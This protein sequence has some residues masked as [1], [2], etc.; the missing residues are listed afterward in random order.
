MPNSSSRPALAGTGVSG[1]D[2]VLKGGLPANRLYLLKGTPGTGKTTLA[3]QFLL[4]GARVGERTLYIALSETGDEIT[5]VAD[6]HG[7]D[8]SPLGIFELST[9]ESQIA[10]EAQNTIYHPAE[11][12]LNK[13]TE[14]I[15]KQIE[16]VKPQRLVI[17]S[18]SELRLLSDSGLRY[19]RQMLSFKQYFAGQ[20]I[21]VLLLDDHGAEESDFHV[22][23]IAHG[24]ITLE[25]L[26]SD[27]GSERRRVRVNKLRGVHFVGGFHD[28]D[29]VTGGLRVY[30]RLIAA[31]HRKRYSGGM[32]TSGIVELDRLLGGGISSGTSCLFLGPSGVGK[33]TAAL[34]FVHTASKA[35]Q[36]VLVCLFDENVR[37]MTTRAKAVSLPLEA[38]IKAGTIELM[39]IDPAELAPGQFL[40]IVRRRVE[41]DVEVVLI[42]SLNGYMQ[43]MPD[44]RFLTVQLHELLS[45]L[46]N[47]GVVTLMTIAQHGLVGQMNTPIDLTYLADA[48][49]LLRFFE[50]HGRIRKAISVIKNRTGNHEAEIREFG[51]DHKGVRVGEPLTAFHGV[52]TG[53]PT[54]TGARENML[55]DR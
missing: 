52:L 27:Y 28:A 1:L 9:L 36:K 29:I 14:L 22:Q 48:V 19:R 24:V 23:S 15:L 54:Y 2:A 25:Q 45:F 16:K 41:Q 13:T 42:D 44:A 20:K 17:D 47:Q 10:E 26:Q 50:E 11:I 21:T 40:E 8:L 4:E 18:V 51:I 6:S 46:G 32:L 43:A 37:T 49:V 31:E 55:P 34:Q 38:A 35:G 7:W 33:S 53:V 12:E 30:P 3:L 5:Q 39:Q